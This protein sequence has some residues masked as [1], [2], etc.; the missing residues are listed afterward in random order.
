MYTLPL[1]M[2]YN[3]KMICKLF[4]KT[5]KCWNCLIILQSEQCVLPQ[6]KTFCCAPSTLFIW[7]MSCLQCNVVIRT[8]CSILHV[9]SV[10]FHVVPECLPL[11]N[12]NSL[13]ILSLLLYPISCSELLFSFLLMPNIVHAHRQH[14]K[15][16]QSYFLFLVCI[17]CCVLI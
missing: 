6:C 16:S 4:L 1:R 7:A 15:L 14:F 17:L 11:I 9:A 12:Y 5:C 3:N 2:E 13:L 10:F 8:V